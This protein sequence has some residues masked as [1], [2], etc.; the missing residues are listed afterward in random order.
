VGFGVGLLALFVSARVWGVPWPW[1]LRHI[2]IHTT[3]TRDLF[4]L[5]PID[6]ISWTLEVEI[7]FYLLAALLAPVLIRGNLR[8]LLC[9][10]LF[11]GALFLWTGNDLELIGRS[12]PSLARLIL[13]LQISWVMITFM[14]IGTLFH[15]HLVRAISTWQLALCA[16]VLFA[17]LPSNGIT[18]F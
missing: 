13:A 1:E 16:T 5:P 6:G 7:K 12:M 17:L 18:A 3:L 11:G 10:A 15:F 4:W 2:L 8:A 9:V 14:F